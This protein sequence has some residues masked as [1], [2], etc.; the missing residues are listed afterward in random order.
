METPT[1]GTR[2]PKPVKEKRI[3]WLAVTFGAQVI[4]FGTFIIAFFTIEQSRTSEMHDMQSELHRLRTS[5]APITF[6][7]DSLT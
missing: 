4:L 3:N 2:T 5:A 1:L 6:S 7:P